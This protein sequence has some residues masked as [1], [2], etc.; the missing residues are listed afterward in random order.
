MDGGAALRVSA[1]S[2][3]RS[4]IRYWSS[5]AMLGYEVLASCARP[6]RAAHSTATNAKVPN[7][8]VLSIFRFIDFPLDSDF[9]TRSR[10]MMN[11]PPSNCFPDFH[12]LSLGVKPLSR[13]SPLRHPYIHG[14]AVPSDHL[15]T[16]ITNSVMGSGP[17]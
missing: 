12:S 7:V 8:I 16:G 4:S 2:V 11:K 15:A 5:G 17:P 6:R 10:P 9:N 13:P 14:A 1:I 3:L